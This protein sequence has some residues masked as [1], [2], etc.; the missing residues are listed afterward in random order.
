MNNFLVELLVEEIP[1]RFQAEAITNFKKLLMEKLRNNGIEFSDVQS[2]VTPRRLVFSANLNDKIPAFI[3]EKKGPQTSAP[4]DIIKK[5]LKAAGVTRKECIEKVID[6]KTFLFAQIE[7]PA[8]DTA[9]LLASIV[10]GAILEIHWPKSMHWGTHSFKFVRPLRNILC[11]FDGKLVNINFDE[12]NIKSTDYTVGHRFISPQK[13]FSKSIDDYLNK[14]RD[15]CVVVDQENRKQII[16]ERCNKLGGKHFA[17]VD[18][19]ENLLN[20]IVGLVEYPVVLVGKI[21]E[22]FMRLPEEVIITS[23]R[24]HQRYFPARNSDGKLAPYFVFVANNIAEDGG[25]TIIAGNQRVLNARLSDALFFLETDLKIPLEFQLEKLKKIVFNEKLGTVFDR[26]TRIIS[27][28]NHLCDALQKGGLNF[29]SGFRDI[30]ERAALLAKCDLPTN[31]VC[32]FTELQGIIGAHYAQ[33]QGEKVEVC[34]II[35]D[36]YKSI[37]NISS[38]AAALFSLADKIEIVTGFFA[39]GKEPTGSKDPFALRRATIGILKIIKKYDLSIDLKEIIQR[40]FDKLCLSIENLNKNTVEKVM[41]FIL[42]RLKVVLKENDIQHEVINAVIFVNNDILQIFKKAEILNEA[43]KVEIGKKLISIYKR[44]KNI[45]QNKQRD[46]IVEFLLKEAE[47][48]NL[49]A[50]TDALKKSID[51]LEKLNINP[52]EKFS[53]KL[54]ICISMEKVMSNFFNNVLVNTDDEKVQKNRVSLLTNL[55]SVLDSALPE[56]S[57]FCKNND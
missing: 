4:Q 46:S 15:A 11:K 12:I 54:T 18:V 16:L 33:L 19:T 43:F 38:I 40:A 10:K 3:E 9:N 5:F 13:I 55:I 37:E 14:M 23:M 24:A 21:P 26:I 17:Y 25:D 45:I 34:E 30:L 57:V 22:K 50:A 29:N 35:R 53:K 36:Q 49:F 48:K 52:I 42:D 8:K 41:E 31:M 27:I 39:I 28:C 32:E 6:K 56:I 47:E 1:A 44:A 7:H 2:Y 20:E 51:D